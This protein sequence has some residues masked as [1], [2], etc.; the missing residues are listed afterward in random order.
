MSMVPLG[1]PLA[2]SAREA[3]KEDRTG[4]WKRGGRLGVAMH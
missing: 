2:V 3:L 4:K 1:N